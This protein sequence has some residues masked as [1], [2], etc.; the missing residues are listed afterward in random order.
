ML[1]NENEAEYYARRAAEEEGLQQRDLEDIEAKTIESAKLY[2]AQ[3]GYTD[4]T[5][6][7][8]M[9]TLTQLGLT[10]EDLPQELSASQD[11]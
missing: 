7:D 1:P 8:V 9:A 3:H 10:Q 11:S 6:E 5:D 4:L 2:L